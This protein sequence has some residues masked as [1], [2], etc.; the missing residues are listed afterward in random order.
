MPTGRLLGRINNRSA[1][2]ETVDVSTPTAVSPASYRR[3]ALNQP[4]AAA[5]NSA[6]ASIAAGLWARTLSAATL[7]ANP[8]WID[9]IEA[10]LPDAAHDLILRGESLYYP[11]NGRLL[12]ASSWLVTGG[13]DPDS[14]TVTATLPGPDTEA[15]ITA[16]MSA[17]L[18]LWWR[19]DRYRPWRGIGPLTSCRTAAQQ[20]ALAEARQRDITASPWGTIVNVHSQTPLSPGFAQTQA[21][22]MGRMMNVLD[23]GIMPTIATDPSSRLSQ[24]EIGGQAKA[25]DVSLLKDATDRVL[26]ACGVPPTLLTATGAAARDTWRWWIA[27]SVEPLARR[28]SGEFSRALRSPVLLDVTTLRQADILARA[29]AVGT[30]VNAGLTPADARNTVGI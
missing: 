25:A 3:R 4:D 30:L 7:N 24:V 22:G 20:V 11:L 8:T 6:A 21:E 1:A 23:G 12:A 15:E 18:W 10:S 16:P 28:L 17:F 26:A 5:T 14:W 13:S 19:R 9:E 27:S 2:T 29:R